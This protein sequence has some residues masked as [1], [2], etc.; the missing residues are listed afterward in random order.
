MKK[1]HIFIIIM[2]LAL[3]PIAVCAQ[4]CDGAY[5]AGSDWT[6][7]SPGNEDEGLAVGVAIERY[8][9]PEYNGGCGKIFVY[10]KKTGKDVFE[11][12]LFYAGK[13]LKGNIG[14]GIYYF[15]VKT[16]NGKTG[17]IGVKKDAD[18]NLVFVTATG[19]ME[20]QP[21]LSESLW[22]REGCGRY[23]DPTPQAN[24]DKELLEMLRLAD[25]DPDISTPGFG[26]RKLF[27]RAHSGLIP[28]RVVY[29]K[30]KG[31]EQVNIRKSYN[32][33]VSLGPLK[34]GQTLPVVDEYNGWC[35]VRMGEREFGWV[36]LKDVTLTNE[37][38]TTETRPRAQGPFSR[39]EADLHLFGLKGSVFKC[40]ET[41]DDV[42][43]V[44]SFSYN[45]QLTSSRSSWGAELYENPQRDANGRI[46]R[47]GDD[48]PNDMDGEV[49]YH[50]ITWRSDAPDYVKSVNFSGPVCD[51]SEKYFYENNEKP[52]LIT[53]IVQ[54]SGDY[55]PGGEITF[56]YLSFDDRGNWT[57]RLVVR[58]YKTEDGGT[59][60]EKATQNRV[61]SYQK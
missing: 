47:Y 4:S 8:T 58:K 52:Y 59:I 24:N 30:P 56:T 53:K 20:G 48:T 6:N 51:V 31:Q 61:I 17:R 37:T 40:I 11:A 14:N 33:P 1:I 29:A 10:D 23:V 44:Y 50:Y 5:P 54:E 2:A 55:C 13:G 28:D 36:P 7:D 38:A 32:N 39:F 12:N 49:D 41:E 22:R 18:A 46:I 42:K 57:R 19:V 21:F 43:V 60:T 26:D 34:V 9:D 45:G 16:V 35:Q 15:D 3:M 25:Q 27:I